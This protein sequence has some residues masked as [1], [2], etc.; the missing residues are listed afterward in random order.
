[1]CVGIVLH[2]YITQ[3][4]KNQAFYEATLH[5]CERVHAEIKHQTHCHF[6]ILFSCHFRFNQKARKTKKFCYYKTN[7][8]ALNTSVNCAALRR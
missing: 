7:A 8:E 5:A 1:M 4:T 6:C 2:I 3:F